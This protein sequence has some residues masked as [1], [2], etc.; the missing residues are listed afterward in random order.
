MPKKSKVFSLEDLSGDSNRIFQILTKGPDFSTAMVGASYLD[1]C[2]DALLRAVLHESTVTDKLLAADGGSLGSFAARADLA[3]V[4]GKIPKP[5]YQD[6]KDIA[7]IRNIFAHTHLNVDFNNAEVRPLCSGLRYLTSLP[8]KTNRPD[9]IGKVPIPPK[10][11][12]AMAVA[13][14]AHRLMGYT[15]RIGRL[16]VCEEK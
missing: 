12:F 15:S 4:L 6:L 7:T 9:L 11:H 14:I 16:P 13:V 2:L 5:L 10:A 1:A 3:Y 8:V